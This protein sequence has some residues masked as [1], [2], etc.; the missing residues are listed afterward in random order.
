MWTPDPAHEA[1]RDLARRPG[2]GGGRS[3]AKASAASFFPA[4]AQPNLQW[5]R[6]W[7]LAHRRWLAGQKFDHAAQQVVFQEGIDA[8]ED[9]LQRLR[10]VEEATRP[11][12]AGVVDG[13][14]G[15]S[16]S[17]HARRFV[18]RRRGPT[19]AAEI[20][21]VR[22]FD[23]PRQLTSFLG[24][25][26]AEKLNRRHNPD[27]RASALAGNR[28]ARRAYLVEAAWTLSLPGE[29]QQDLASAA[30]EGCPSR[31][32]H[33]LEGANP[34]VCA[35][36]RRL[37]ATGRSRLSSWLRSPARSPAFL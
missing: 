33:R 24:L 32:R 5:R 27:G 14:G 29:G 3:S 7:T 12:R 34:S 19:F 9:S 18:S 2:G 28:R 16:L 1:V 10:R 35:R 30:R 11:R 26:P 36:Y 25:V 37:S 20:G 6:H 4:A 21:D 15:G 23:T 8:I 22:R 17:S 13:A 31:P